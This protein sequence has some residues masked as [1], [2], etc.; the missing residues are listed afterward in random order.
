MSIKQ[1][2][3]Q[4]H[5]HPRHHH[6]KNDFGLTA[7][8]NLLEDSAVEMDDVIRGLG[9]SE[10]LSTLVRAEAESV[11]KASVFSREVKSLKHAVA[12]LGLNRL[13][14]LLIVHKTLQDQEFNKSA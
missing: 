13:H 3:H 8:L 1:S 9:K 6:L 10:T 11:V 7:I 2:H 4:A 12:L 14:A 5:T